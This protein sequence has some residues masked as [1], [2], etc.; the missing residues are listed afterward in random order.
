MKHLRYTKTTNETTGVIMEKSLL[1]SLIKRAIGDRTLNGFCAQAGINAGNLSRILRGQKASADV[2]LKIAENAQNGITS[3]DLFSAAGYTRKPESSRIMVYGT[4]AA[5]NPLFAYEDISGYIDI[6]G[7]SGSPD[8]YFALKVSG[9]SMD[10]AHIP[11]GCTVIVH[12]Q[13]TLEDGDIGV[14]IIDG[15]ATVKQFARVSQ[16]V[17][18]LPMSSDTRHKPQIY[19]ETNRVDVLGKVIKAILDI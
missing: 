8:D 2:L 9:N 11:D 17:M 19:D 6:S 13:N 16:T 4:V 10:L 5:G 15:D 12:K 18:L 1:Q 3:E 7:L 14:F